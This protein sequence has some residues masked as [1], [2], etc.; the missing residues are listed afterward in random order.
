M[1]KVRQIGKTLYKTLN[2]MLKSAIRITFAV[3]VI[4]FT[5]FPFGSQEQEELARLNRISVPYISH[6]F[7]FESFVFITVDAEVYSN[8]VLLDNMDTSASGVVIQTMDDTRT[9]ML[10]AGHVC[11][12]MFG[13]PVQPSFSKDIK[14]TVYDYYGGPHVASIVNVGSSLDLCL[15]ESDDIWSHGSPL[16][17]F[18]PITGEKVYT[19][20]APHAIFSPGN[21]LLFD[22][23]YT[24]LDPH[25]NAFYTVPTKPG[26]SGAGIFNNHGQ[27]I[28]IIHSAPVEFE[29]LAIAS[30]LEQVKMFVYQSVNVVVTF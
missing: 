8:D 27:I 19:I 20:S 3:G 16:A 23:Y 11:D 29:N 24:G 15:L 1:N 7:P 21:A 22:G 2:S 28:G 18:S 30:S 9:Y 17:S 13:P 14:I 25:M 4:L 10:T 5:I 12:P 26:S 6:D